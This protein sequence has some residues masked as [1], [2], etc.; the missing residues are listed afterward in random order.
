M[1]FRGAPHLLVA[2]APKAAPCPL[3]DTLI[4]L[5]TFQLLAHARGVGTVWDG[6]FMMALGVCPELA[7]QLQIPDD[8]LVGFA[9]A[10]GEPA[11]EYHRTVQRGPARV[12]AVR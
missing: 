9:M 4:A 12:H 10:F 3:Q 7:S 11:V 5:T 2:S 8:H 1:I 6:M